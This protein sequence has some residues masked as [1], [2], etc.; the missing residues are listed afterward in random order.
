MAS[1]RTGELRS[2]LAVHGPARAA[3]AMAHLGVS[4]SAFSRL[5]GSCGPEILTVGRARATRY[6]ASREI[7]ELG[8]SV[9]VFEVLA[10]GGARRLGTLHAVLPGSSFYFEALADDAESGMFDDLPYLLED[11]RPAGFLGRLVPLQHPDLRL[12][13]DI[14][15][16]TANHCLSFLTRYGWNAPGSLIVGEAA[17]RLHME[18]ALRPSIVIEDHERS[19]RYLEVAEDVLSHGA[20]GSSAAGEQPKFLVTRAP[21]PTPVLVKFSPPVVDAA[22]ARVADLLIAE[23]HALETLLAFG[24]EAPR[25]E[26]LQ[27]RGRTFLEVER[28]DR[29]PTGG[30]RGLVSLRALDL[31]FVGGSSSWIDA[32]AKLASQRRIDESMLVAIRRR[33]LFGRLIANT[34]MHGGNLS[35]FTRGTTILALAPAYDMAPAL[36]APAYGQLRTPPFEPA[37]PDPSDAPHW[38][39]ACTAALEL[40][41]RVASDGRVS[42]P[43]RE[44]AAANAAVVA[45]ARELQRLLPAG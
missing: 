37:L 24:Q 3:E 2:F 23:L 19:A 42:A 17:F 31:Q 45:R 8:R 9:P 27:A 18:H 22:S 32:A 33:Q 11:L 36:Y 5:L 4:H 1:D 15:L 44:V 10:D 39:D 40:W 16:W 41:N 28:F 26:L 20:P 30:R 43:F 12:P 6:L 34:D 38:T 14:Q 35:F 25:A 29:L 7:P 13:A 21:G